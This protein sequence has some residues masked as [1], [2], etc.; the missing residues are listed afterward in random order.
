M[1]IAII[2]SFAQSIPPF[3]TDSLDNYI[4]L[5]MQSWKIP[6]V[7][8]CIVKDGQVIYEKGL[9]VTEWGKKESVN[10]QT[11]FPIASITKTFTGTALAMLEAE[12]KVSLDDQLTKWLPSFKMKDKLYEEQITL[13]DILSHRSGWKTFQGDLLNTESS[14]EK[15][16]MLEKFGQLQPAYPIR[17]RFGY[18][19]FGFM[20][21]GEVFRPISGNDWALSVKNL[22]LEPLKMQRTIIYPDQLAT[23]TNITSKHTVK[24]DTIV[25]L[26]PDKVDIQSYGG[27]YSTVHDLAIWMNTLLNKGVCNGESVIPEKAINKMWTS[28]TIIGKGRA[29]DRQFYLKTYGLGWEI[30]QYN[31]N[32]VIQHGGAYS[33]VLTMI[34]MI[35]SLNLGIAILTNS[36][37]HM[38][39]EIL[40]WQVFD[41]FINRQAPNYI[42]SIIEYQQK[43]KAA[44]QVAKQSSGTTKNMITESLAIPMEQLTGTY[45]CDA[46][47]K[48][49]INKKGANYILTLEYHPQLEGAL[50]PHSKN[51]ITC[52]YNHPMF[53]QTNLPLT[54]ENNKVKGFTLFVD[55]FVEA[56]GYEFHKI[57]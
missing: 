37:D 25:V 9:G 24:N 40:K 44:E 51:Q 13:T 30:M 43:K 22:I 26:K 48:C 54:I 45:L 19:N 56:G 49:F 34:G 18:S 57:E 12:G 17:T 7:A 3:V 23:A 38:L 50:S 14:M 16:T 28:H 11:L 15:S 1:I 29:A 27:I 10:E 33:G 6:G 42:K 2:G 35:P 5:A 52:T 47:G 32:E 46:Y 4:Q 36:D 41:A 55:P 20:L 39:Q 8:V 21:A 31:G 53:G